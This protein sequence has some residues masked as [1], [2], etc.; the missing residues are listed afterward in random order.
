MYDPRTKF[1]LVLN[2]EKISWYWA[3]VSGSKH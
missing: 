1:S 3:H 2:N